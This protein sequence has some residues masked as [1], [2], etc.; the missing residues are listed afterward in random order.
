MLKVSRESEKRAFSSPYLLLAAVL[1]TG[2]FVVLRVV[3]RA[4]GA[5]DDPFQKL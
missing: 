2:H 3:L 5:L 4:P 1:M